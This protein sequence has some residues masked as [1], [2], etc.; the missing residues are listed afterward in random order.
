MERKRLEG[1]KAW[2]ER[3]SKN[4]DQLEKAR[5]KRLEAMSA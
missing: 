1:K 3:W 5:A 2:S 4:Y